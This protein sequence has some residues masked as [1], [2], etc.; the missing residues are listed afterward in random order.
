MGF[1][2]FYAAHANFS[3]RVVLNFKDS[4]Q[5][6]LEAT[7]AALDLVADNEVQ[8]II[9]PQTSEDAHIIGLMCNK[10]H[11]PML[12]FSSSPHII[13]PSS[14]PYL[15]RANIDD[16]FLAEPIASFVHQH[17][18]LNVVLV[19]DD[20]NFGTGIL[21]SFTKAL[22]EVNIVISDHVIIPI[23]ATDEFIETELKILEIKNIRVFIVNLT[24]LFASRLFVKISKF[25]MMNERYVW[26]ATNGVSS[27]IEA[28]DMDVLDSMQGLIGGKFRFVEGQ[29]QLSTFEV[30][31]VIGKGV[32]VV[33]FWTPESGITGT[34]NSTKSMKTVIWPGDTLVASKGFAIRASANKLRI[35]VPSNANE[36]LVNFMNKTKP[37]GYCID[38]F[39]A[40]MRELS[41]VMSYQYFAVSPDTYDELIDMVT[42][43]EFDAAV[44][45]VTILAY[46]SL[47]VDF[48]FSFV[49]PG[50]S[51]VVPIKDNRHAW[52]FLKPLTT[53][54]WIASVFF[55]FFTGFVI[56][57]IE[58][59][60]NPE[61][62]GTPSQQLGVTFY[63]AFSTLVF[64]HKE[65]VQSN[66]SRFAMI[67]WLFVVLVLTSSYTASFTS[68]LTVQ[69]LQATANLKDLIRRGDYVGYQSN[70]VWD[71]LLKL[72]LDSR[73]LVQYDSYDYGFALNTGSPYGGV[74]AI[75]DEIPYIKLFLSNHCADHYA[76]VGPTYESN[77]FGFV[78]QKGS[79]LVSDINRAIL[80]LKETGEMHNIRYKWFH[81]LSASC[82]PHN[83]SINYL[84]LS[85]GNF[86]GLF[87]IT[88]VVSSI[89]LLISILIFIFT[90]WDKLKS[91]GSSESSTWKRLHAWLKLYDGK[92]ND[93]FALKK[94]NEM[95]HSAC[96]GE[97]NGKVASIDCMTEIEM[98]ASI[99]SRS[100]Q[101]DIHFGS[102]QG[103]NV[104]HRDDSPDVF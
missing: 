79:P 11:V 48:S 12:T 52:I 22:K 5:D 68:I 41:P 104:K 38:V 6:A 10:S 59:R 93:S 39:D 18:W 31:N 43:K 90:E 30:V 9:G 44:G 103:D 89:M 65:N 57:V 50:I 92:D 28:L 54:L 58:H 96:V 81:N 19:Y 67:V 87:T 34:L 36:Q 27:V 51:M 99:S 55:F 17:G 85:F 78:F 69:R 1:E 100:S 71:L 102:T 46:R 40:V 98:M 49:E 32:R 77:G 26:I 66:L 76:M 24:P 20:S 61:F 75:F 56:W 95:L 21:P 80:S 84:R 45:D 91:V 88:G 3:T 15:F 62:R 72:G 47:Y 25:G 14:N 70:F 33:G 8:V 73:K 83:A 35:V 86:A 74:A 94:H 29:L 4:M 64:S 63:Y 2:D 13:S 82:Q 60:I 101:G 37:T 7:S 16:S 42:R 53:D 23:T 97:E